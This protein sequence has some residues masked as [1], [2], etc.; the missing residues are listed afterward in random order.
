MNTSRK[1]LVVSVAGI[2]IFGIGVWMRFNA[3]DLG[4][5]LGVGDVPIVANSEQYIE[6]ARPLIWCGLGLFMFGVVLWALADG[7]RRG[8]RERER[9]AQGYSG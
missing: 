6:L 7:I 3:E 9:N 4:T 2:L 5:V 1:S 8:E